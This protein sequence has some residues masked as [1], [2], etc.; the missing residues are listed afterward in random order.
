MPRKAGKNGL[1]MF[2]KSSCRIDGQYVLVGG[3]PAAVCVRCGEQ[4]FS[5]ETIEKVRT[6]IHGEAKA[7]KDERRPV[8]TGLSMLR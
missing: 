2:S 4:A 6:M 5:R 7:A 8:C 1:T 3:I